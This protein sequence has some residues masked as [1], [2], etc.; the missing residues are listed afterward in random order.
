MI[1]FKAAVLEKQSEPLRI[2]TLE[3]NGE[4]QY[5]Q[6]FVKLITSG[7][8]GA[9]INEISGVKGV[10]KYLPHMMGHEGFAEVFNIGPG[11]SKVKKGDLVV[12]HWRKGSGIDAAPA[13]FGSEIG[14]I[15]SGPVTTFSEYSIVS[16][17]RV[18]KLTEKIDP[19]SAALLGC[20]VTT[21]FG[22]FKNEIN[23]KSIK[24]AIVIGAG[25]LGLNVVQALKYNGIERVIAVDILLYK[26]NISLKM[27]ASHFILC[28]DGN[29]KNALQAN[30][31]D[32]YSFDLVIDTTGS[33][34]LISQGFDMLN[35][36]GILLLVGQ[37]RIDTKLIINNP[38][39]F[40]EG[41]SIFAS[42]GGL[43]NP[44]VDIPELA[45]LISMNIIDAKNIITHKIKLNDINEG[46]ETLKSGLSG[47]IVIGHG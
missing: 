18:T 1:K 7:I 38:L 6:I 45:K 11:V 31:K 28:E 40:F 26:K 34:Q 16:E 19:Y 9:Q 12:L 41:K 27:G 24:S 33:N 14:L 32:N 5:G 10:D 43:T 25:G 46:L 35:K 42:D 37:P 2:L 20:G 30:L 36:S 23:T 4:L 21:A 47:R 3:H 39:A 15:G 29:L 17:N 8:C 44:D 22:I 13:K